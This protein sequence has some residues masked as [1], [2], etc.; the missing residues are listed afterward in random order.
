[1][2]VVHE[3]MILKQLLVLIALT[4]QL[5]NGTHYVINCTGPSKMWQYI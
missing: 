2:F 3:E 5:E 1:M 4:L